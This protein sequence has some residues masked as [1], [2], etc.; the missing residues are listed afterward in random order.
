MKVRKG[1]EEAVLCI[2]QDTVPH[3][4]ETAAAFSAERARL[5][6]LPLASGSLENFII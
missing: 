4:M 2:A 6:P 1:L 3:R 5:V